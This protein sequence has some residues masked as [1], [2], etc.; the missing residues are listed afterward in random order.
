MDISN[1]ISLKFNMIP[2]NGEFS[3]KPWDA[4]TVKQWLEE[5]RKPK[6]L[7]SVIYYEMPFLKNGQ[8]MAYAYVLPSETVPLTEEEKAFYRESK[9]TKKEKESVEKQKK[10][11]ALLDTVSELFDKNV[12]VFDTETTGFSPAKGD[13]ILSLSVVEKDGQVL[14]E[15]F[16]KP[17]SKRDWPQAQAVHGISPKMV[18]NKPSA[19]SA[20]AEVVS[21]FENAD[22]IVGHNVSFDVRFIESTFG[23]SIPPEKVF[24]TMKIAKAFSPGLSSY[25]L[26]SVVKE[27]VPERLDEHMKGAHGSTTDAISTAMVFSY[28]AQRTKEL[29]QGNEQDDP[30]L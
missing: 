1:A 7:G 17:E 30:E 5:G 20:R 11:D 10:E 29:E 22:A 4:K 8:R 3:K 24:D 16:F 14:F 26:E 23:I 28:I 19:Q 9:I 18:E 6:S 13:E 2:S 12:I 25:T 27:F 21:I 15:S